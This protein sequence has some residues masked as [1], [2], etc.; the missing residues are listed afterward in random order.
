MSTD[1]FPLPDVVA[2]TRGTV[3]LVPVVL[4]V[5][6]VVAWLVRRGNRRAVESA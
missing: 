4:G 2:V 3:Y 1:E 6:A 5:L